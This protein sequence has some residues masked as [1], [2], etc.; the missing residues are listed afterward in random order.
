M[1][2]HFSFFYFYRMWNSLASVMNWD[3]RMVD[4]N[5][6]K[7]LHPLVDTEGLGLIGGLYCP[8]DGS[9]DPTG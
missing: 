5:E 9:I 4:V 6:I 1:C 8:S 7:E 3:C 2:M